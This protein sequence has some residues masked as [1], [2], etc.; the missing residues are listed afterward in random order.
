MTKMIN[1]IPTDIGRPIS[2]ITSKLRYANIEQDAKEVLATLI[3]KEVE[4]KD[5]QGNYFTVRISPYRTVENVIDGVVITFLDATRIKEGDKARRLATIVRDSND[6]I[7]VQNFDG[8][9]TDWNKGAE[10]MYGWSEAEALKMNISD[11]VPK[12]RR[13]EALSLVKVVESGKKIESFETQRLTK[14]G[15]V[16]DVWLTVTKLVDEDGLPVEIATTER[17]LGFIRR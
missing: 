9:I 4:T 15:K 6:A 16:L 5:D 13:K 1:L 3:H 17:D 10:R 7:T 14:D 12:G 8:N 11:L 2:H